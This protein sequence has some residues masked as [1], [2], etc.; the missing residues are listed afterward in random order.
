M[1]P[2]SAMEELKKTAYL[3]I[4]VGV[5]MKTTVNANCTDIINIHTIYRVSRVT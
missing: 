5:A 1:L 3:S 4:L 2:Y